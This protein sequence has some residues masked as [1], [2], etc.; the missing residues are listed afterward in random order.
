MPERWSRVIGFGGRELSDQWSAFAGSSGRITPEYAPDWAILKQNEE[1][2]YLVRETKSTRDYFNLR[3]TEA[4]KIRCG[5][6]HF[7]TLGVPF[8]VVVKADEV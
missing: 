8:G 7:Q 3:N 5:A 6:K 1:V 4:D 2:L